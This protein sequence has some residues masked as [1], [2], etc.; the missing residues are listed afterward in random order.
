MIDDL[1]YMT[2]RLTV[3]L[4]SLLT[5]REKDLLWDILTFFLVHPP[6]IIRL[7][8]SRIWVSLVDLDSFFDCPP[9][10]DFLKG[11]H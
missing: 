4:A 7:S 1:L 8:I 5:N 9:F 11:L 3:R 6:N 2:H 10:L